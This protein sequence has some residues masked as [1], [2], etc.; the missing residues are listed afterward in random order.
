MPRQLEKQ[1]CLIMQE[2]YFPTMLFPPHAGV[3]HHAVFFVYF[4][5]ID[6]KA[7]V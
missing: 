2:R 4:W 5:G 1:K 3:R 7:Q 6:M